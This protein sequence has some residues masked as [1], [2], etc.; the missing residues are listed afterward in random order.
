[1]SWNLYNF[2]NVLLQNLMRMEHF[3]INIIKINLTI[4]ILETNGPIEMKFSM[5]SILK[6]NSAFCLSVALSTAAG[7]GNRW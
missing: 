7:Y 3:E 6:I 1:M 2:F 4:N 5:L